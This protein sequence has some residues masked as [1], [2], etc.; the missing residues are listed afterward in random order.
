MQLEQLELLGWGSVGIVYKISKTIA[1]KKVKGIDKGNQ[2]TNEHVVFDLLDKHPSCPNI[3]QS[4]YR[5]PS[6]I[7]LHL[8]DGGTL[9]QRLRERQRRDPVSNLVVEVNKK[10]PP[11]LLW[12]WTAEMTD[13]I[14]WLE[15]LGFA[16]GD[17]RPP[18]LLLDGEDHL[19]VSDFDS[20]AAI[21][22][23]FD[24]V[25]PP[26]ARVMGDEGADD[27]GTFGYHGSRTE[28]FAIGSVIYTMT[29]GFEPYEDQSLGEDH[30]ATIV[31]YLQA[32]IFPSIGTSDMDGLIREC[33][34]GN[35]SSI[36][37]LH[38]EVLQIY[39]GI[40]SMMAKPIDE[41][42]CDT[43]K[44][45][46]M[47][48]VAEGILDQTAELPQASPELELLE[49]TMNRRQGLASDTAAPL[50]RIWS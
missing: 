13:A 34:H 29:R 20:T 23:V 4:F 38:C 16:H 42:K 14:A 12:R 30:E 6:A 27:R 25:Q 2:P 36:R 11:Q 8:M 26:W 31:D 49:G 10:D 28:Q 35:Y 45:L 18:N 37:D 15:H 5:V 24:G 47:Q 19:K 41:S 46:C 50:L 9:D 32:K 48:L 40:Q 43:A 39:P 17:L 21:G 7:F 33:W 22:E 44:R 1:M 3:V